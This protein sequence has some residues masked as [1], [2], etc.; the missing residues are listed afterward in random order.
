MLT[1]FCSSGDSTNDWL[2]T[3]R[4]LAY[5]LL[6]LSGNGIASSYLNQPIEVDILRPKL[7]SILAT[8]DIPQI[9]IRVGYA[10]I[11]AAQSSRRSLSEVITRS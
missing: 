11:E 4:A 8:T 7:R 10:Q 1:V 2:Q 9:L 3:G 5:V 6:N